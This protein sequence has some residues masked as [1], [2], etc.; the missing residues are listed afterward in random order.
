MYENNTGFLFSIVLKSSDVK[1][2]RYVRN[3][4]RHLH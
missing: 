2:Q 3:I 1:E 4:R